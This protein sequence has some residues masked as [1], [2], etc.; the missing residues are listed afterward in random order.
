MDSSSTE[1]YSISDYEMNESPL[2][3]VMDAD[4]EEIMSAP[5]NTLNIPDPKMKSPEIVDAVPLRVVAYGG[6]EAIPFDKVK[7][8]LLRNQSVHVK[9]QCVRQRKEEVDIPRSLKSRKAY[10]E[11]DWK[12]FIDTGIDGDRRDW[13]FKHRVYRRNFRSKR[14]VKE[15]LDTNGPVTGKFRGKKLHKKKIRSLDGQGS[16]GRSKSRG[17]RAANYAN[18]YVSVG[19]GPSIWPYLPQGFV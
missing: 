14:Q 1:S 15:F 8:D 11:G 10:K 3:A 12:A 6:K 2:P 13:S 18:V 17:R 4:E 16:T 7:R 5:Q 9:A 19:S